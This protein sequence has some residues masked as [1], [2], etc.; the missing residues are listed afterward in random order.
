MVRINLII[1]ALSKR[2]INPLDPNYKFLGATNRNIRQDVAYA[3]ENTYLPVRRPRNR[4]K[5]EWEK[6]TIIP[7]IMDKP[8]N[9]IPI[10]DTNVFTSTANVF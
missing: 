10:Q 7:V 4:Y 2:M 3:E 1:G 8:I 5:P 9:R 6:N